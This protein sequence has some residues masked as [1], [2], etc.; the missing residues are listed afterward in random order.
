MPTKRAILDQ[1]SAKE[2][3]VA[4]DSHELHVDDRRVKAQLVDAL[5]G[6]RKAK[7]DE[8]LPGTL[9]ESPEGVV[10]GIQP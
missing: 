9:P 6:S 4:I 10:P 8:L 2:L 7:L 1:L 5:A 3:R